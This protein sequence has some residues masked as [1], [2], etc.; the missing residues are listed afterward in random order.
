MQLDEARTIAETLRDLL[1]PACEEIV[2][3][4]SIRREKAEVKDVELVCRPI[5]RMNLFGEPAGNVLAAQ[6]E[7]AMAREVHLS[8]DRRTPRNG[9]RYKRFWWAGWN[10]SA[11]IAVDLFIAD[12][13]NFGN[14]LAIRTGN[15]EF[16]QLLVTDRTHGG[17]MPTAI[18]GN[19]R[20]RL[21]QNGG[22]LWRVP[23]GRYVTSN[24]PTPDGSPLAVPERV[25]CPDEAAF[26][27]TLGIVAV[28]E[29]RE[30]DAACIARLRQAMA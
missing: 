17:M 21:W 28:P 19:G 4:G 29:P 24:G 13:D 2:I 3:A 15:A 27:A 16:S 22:Y 5:A 1:R 12:R 10:P 9:E 18:G 7:A 20:W 25:S 26:F 11:G 8:W 23:A 6:I 14:T 30:R